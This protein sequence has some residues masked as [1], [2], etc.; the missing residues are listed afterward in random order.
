MHGG[1]GSIAPVRETFAVGPVLEATLRSE[2][3]DRAVD[4]DS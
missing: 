4:L 2:P 3:R 1:F